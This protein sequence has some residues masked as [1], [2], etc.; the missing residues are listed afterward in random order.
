MY[1]YDVS[2]ADM[3]EDRTRQFEKFGIPLEDIERVAA[4]TTDMWADARGDHP[5]LRPPRHR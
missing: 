5:G 3:F 4:A 1:T 2:A